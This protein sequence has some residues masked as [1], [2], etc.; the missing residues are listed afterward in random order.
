MTVTTDG[1]QTVTLTIPRPNFPTG[2][3]DGVGGDGDTTPTLSG[4]GSGS[5]TL[6]PGTG[7]PSTGTGV[8]GTDGGIPSTGTGVPGTGSGTPSIGTGVPSTDGGLPS[9]GTGVPGTG[10]GILSTGTGIPSTETGTSD[11][12]S[13]TGNPTLPIDTRTGGLETSPSGSFTLPPSSLNSTAPSGTGTGANPGTSVGTGGPSPPG[14]PTLSFDT[15]TDSPQSSSSAPSGSF[16]LPPS[17]FNSTSPGT[18]STGI[19][20][21]TGTG[22]ASTGV[23]VPPT[24]TSTLAPTATP[25]DFCDNRNGTIYTTKCQ[26]FEILCY[27]NYA[28]PVFEGFF[29]ESLNECIEECANVNV[30]FSQDRCYGLVYNVTSTSGSNC[31]FKTQDGVNDPVED[32][33]I[34]AA[35]LVNNNTCTTRFPSNTNPTGFVNNT[36]L[37]TPT[38]SLNLNVSSRL[39][40][41][42]PSASFSSSF[43]G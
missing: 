43:S 28:G 19:V 35:K 12:G 41:S 33:D 36:I 26:A 31:F 22:I 18:A 17:S 3:R 15:R 23:V 14:Q 16:T 27:A 42:V 9:T 34:L 40:T 39:G 37:S 6:P 1:V 13:F 21:S 5:A 11:G 20:T 24:N 25:R 10:S 4:P 32:R 29:E 7:I 38:G 2:P 30:G 8:P